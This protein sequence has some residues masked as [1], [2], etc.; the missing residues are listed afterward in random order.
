MTELVTAHATK[1]CQGAF[2]TFLS[3]PEK[4]A[5]VGRGG[6]AAAARPPR[7][8]AMPKA[9]PAQPRSHWSEQLPPWIAPH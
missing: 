2:H 3:K 1:E 6:S 5:A 4:P 8:T 7:P 9:T